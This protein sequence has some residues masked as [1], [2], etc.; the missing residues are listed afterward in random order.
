MCGHVQQTLVLHFIDHESTGIH[1]TP[2]TV[3]NWLLDV[4]AAIRTEAFRMSSVCT[5]RVC[6]RI[7]I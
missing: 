4:Q 2:P 1:M 7:F 6:G 3:A 5:E